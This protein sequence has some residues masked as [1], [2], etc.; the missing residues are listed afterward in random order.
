MKSTKDVIIIGG[1]PIG[2]FTAF[3]AG[4][5]QLDTALIESLPQLGGQLSTLYPEKYIYDIAG[6]PKVKAQDLI[7]QL[8]AQ[9]DQFEQDY[10][11]GETVETV[12]R[13]EDGTFQITTNKDE[14]HTKAIII[15]AGNGAF[16]AR[17][18][19]LDGCEDYANLHYFVDNMEKFRDRRVMIA[20]GG[21]SAVDWA[22]M[23]E[24]IA[25]E[26]HIVHRRDRFRAHEHTVEQMKA[27]T[28]NVWTPYNI[29]SLSGETHIE[30]VELTD[31]DGESKFVEIDDLICN[32]GFVSSLGPI[33]NWGMEFEKNTIRVDSRMETTVAG[34][35]ACGDIATYEGKVKLI[36]TGFG[37]APIAIN[38]VK[39]LVD[40]TARHPQHSTS[41][42]AGK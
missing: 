24:G 7:D 21:D 3:Y 11:L 12:E 4:M 36:A 41:V 5:R 13:L 40:P 2:L 31:K 8:K 42:F 30:S 26:V 10:R 16:A 34:I 33:K 25:K 17:P 29:E 22:L 28:I 19:G 38:Q 35:F 1:G 15:T 14:Y 23:L 32:Y 20:G 39:Q 37:E 6:F 9:A 18:L 27:S